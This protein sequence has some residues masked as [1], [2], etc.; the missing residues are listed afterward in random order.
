MPNKP[1]ISHVLFKSG[2]LKGL[3]YL[4]VI[5]YLYIENLADDVKHVAGTSIGSFFSIILAL[6]I[7]LEFLETKLEEMIKAFADKKEMVINNLSFAKL[8][9]SNG[10][11][12]ID[13]LVKPLREYVKKEYDMDD[14]T[15]VELAKKTGVCIYISCTNVNTMKNRIFSVEDSPDVSIFDAATA[16]MSI[17]FLYEPVLI[18]NNFYVDGVITKCIN[19]TDVFSRVPKENILCL[20]LSNCEMFSISD[21]LSFVNYSLN[22]IKT[23]YRTA[24][25][26]NEKEIHDPEAYHVLNLTD[27][28]FDKVISFTAIDEELVMDCTQI[29]LENLILKGFIDMT[30][31]MKKRYKNNAIDI[32]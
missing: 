11:C 26:G 18:E 22:I 24:L 23:I 9:I 30:E 32:K 15:F 17:P 16:S 27:L 13:F 1:N 31:Y 6:K 7:P 8:F 12:T 3:C 5:R 4:G 29:D 21:D 10:I 28:P 2:G 19:P 20:L 25:R 14:M